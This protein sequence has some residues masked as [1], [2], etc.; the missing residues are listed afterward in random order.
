MPMYF[1][2]LCLFYTPGFISFSSFTFMIILIRIYAPMIQLYI[3]KTDKDVSWKKKE[4]KKNMKMKSEFLFL[5][6]HNF[7][8]LSQYS[9]WQKSFE[10]LSFFFFSGNYISKMLKLIYNNGMWRNLN[11]IQYTTYNF[12][13]H[14]WY[15]LL[16]SFSPQE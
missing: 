14:K 1:S 15:F 9:L 3:F 10:F 5:I 11:G 2:T 6:L 7:L 12:W 4:E 8:W 13:T 16:M